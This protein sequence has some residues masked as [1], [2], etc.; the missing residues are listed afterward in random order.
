MNI[1]LT[2]QRYL[3]AYDDLDMLDRNTISLYK[4][5]LNESNPFIQPVLQQFVIKF[6]DEIERKKREKEAIE[7]L[8]DYMEH[9]IMNY[10]GT[11]YNSEKV[12]ETKMEQKDLLKELDTINE[13]ITLLEELLQKNIKKD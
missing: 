10:D 4:S 12:E 3:K 1:A 6:N 11:N 9:C 8:Y 7:A 13:K 2:D 5:A